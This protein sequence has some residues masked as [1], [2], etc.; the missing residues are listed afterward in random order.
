MGGVDSQKSPVVSIL[1][2]TLYLLING[3]YNKQSEM[4]SQNFYLP[5][6]I[7]VYFQHNKDSTYYTITTELSIF[8]ET[9]KATPFKRGKSWNETENSATTII[10]FIWKPTREPL[11]TA[12]KMRGVW[13]KTEPTK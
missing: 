2:T 9:K 13:F 7:C 10:C 11:K 6:V 4:I 5:Y 12:N 1:R 8:I 3:K